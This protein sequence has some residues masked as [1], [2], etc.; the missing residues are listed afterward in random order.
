MNNFDQRKF[1]EE[2]NKIRK[3]KIP[4]CSFCGGNSFT[5]PE[6]ICSVILSKSLNSMQLGV[7]MP[8]GML[9]CSRCG[10]IEFF[11]L[12]ALGLL[13]KEGDDCGGE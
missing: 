13:P 9:I 4:N 5:I 3:N 10:H 2:L 11:A 7:S 1:L 8:S 6:E 12:G